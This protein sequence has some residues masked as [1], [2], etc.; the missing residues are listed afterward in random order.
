MLKRAINSDPVE[1][2]TARMGH[3]L[4]QVQ[5]AELARLFLRLPRL[6]EQ[7]REEIRKLSNV[8]VATMLEPPLQAMRAE[9]EEQNLSA[10]VCA[11]EQLFQLNKIEAFHQPEYITSSIQKRASTLHVSSSDLTH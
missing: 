7:S 5:H 4:A 6:S 8:L 10:L 1:A 2:I 11:L 9:T 3:A